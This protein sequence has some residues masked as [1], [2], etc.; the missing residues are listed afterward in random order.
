MKGIVIPIPLR[1]QSYSEKQKSEK[2]SAIFMQLSLTSEQA[3]CNTK[4]GIHN[5]SYPWTPKPME[6][7]AFAPA[8]YGL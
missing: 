8:K 1:L 6:N 4:H 7:E 5:N 2:N 3:F